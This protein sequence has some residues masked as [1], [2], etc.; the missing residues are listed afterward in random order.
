MESSE[1]LMLSSQGEKNSPENTANIC[2]FFLEGKCRFGVK[3]LNKHGEGVQANSGVQNVEERS[4]STNDSEKVKSAGKS[5][6]NSGNKHHEKKEVVLN[7]K[8]PPMKTASDVISRIQW[9]E[10]LSPKDFVVGY[11][12]R[13]VGIVEKDFTDLSWEDLASVDHFVDLAI[14]RH[15]IQYFKYLG[16]IVWD[17]RSVL[18]ESLDLQE[19]MR[20]FW[21]SKRGSVC[22]KTLIKSK[23]QRKQYLILELFPMLQSF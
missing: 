6:Y 4:D 18:I 7:K 21:M 13:F 3:C 22:H 8:K 2:K 1:K 23:S 5:V 15:R 20:P 14:P 10:E 19:A 16:E 17:K 9:D 12:D 11:L